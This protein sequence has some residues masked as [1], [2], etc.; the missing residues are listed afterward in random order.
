MKVTEKIKKAE[1]EDRVWYVSF[2]FAP[3]FALHL[4]PLLSL[5]LAGADVEPHPSSLYMLG[6]SSFG[7]F[8]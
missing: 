7:A 1:E 5:A 8:L 3:S 4:C 6:N 2:H